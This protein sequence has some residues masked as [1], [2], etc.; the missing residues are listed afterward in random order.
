MRARLRLLAGAVLAV[1]AGAAHA[2]TVAVHAAHL[3]DVGSGKMI[4]DAV[5]VITDGR[6]SARGAAAT[7]AVPAGAKRIDLGGLTMLPGLIDMHVHLSDDPMISGYRELELVDSF[8][9][10]VG[11]ANAA[12]T[13]D[14]GFTTVRNVGSRNFDDV[15]LKQAIERGIIRGPRIVPATYAIC[16]TGGPCDSTELPPSLVRTGYTGVTNGPDALRARVRELRKYGAEV[17]KFNGTGGVLAKGSAVGAQQFSYA[18]MAALVSE[19]HLLGMKVAMHAH[20]ASGINDGLR[21]GVDTIEHASLADEELFRLAKANG[22]WFSMDIYDDDYILAEGAKNGMY[23][24]LLE[25][26]R[27][28]GLKQRQVF[29]AAHAAGVKMVYGTDAGTYP[30]GNNS[31]QFAKMVEWGMTPIE[32]IQS[33]TVNAAQALGRSGDVGTL[34][35]G[36]YGDIIAVA[37]DPRAD[38]TELTRV[39]VVIKGGAVVRDDSAAKGK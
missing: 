33:A 4:D 13:L 9:M 18:E 25:K 30:N 17:I 19:A 35:V 31:V 7:V 3:L 22:A 14:G 11:V 10:A 1:L 6:V 16:A 32:A 27:A 29:R 37:G 23:P 38:V 2:E 21:A 34:A 39:R 26:E 28:V 36:Q 12:K 20:G 5:V 24:E 15:G 8:W